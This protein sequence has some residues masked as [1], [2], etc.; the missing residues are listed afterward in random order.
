ME[1]SLEDLVREW[2]LA[3]LAIDKMTV[4]E[5]RADERPLDRLVAAHQALVAYADEELIDD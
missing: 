5:R 2:R 4:D 1:A 3:Q